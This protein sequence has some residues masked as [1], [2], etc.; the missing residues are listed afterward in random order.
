[1][2]CDVHG[3]CFSL[4]GIVEKRHLSLTWH[5]EI[6]YS[7]EKDRKKQF[8]FL[9]YQIYFEFHWK[10]LCRYLAIR[11]T[12]RLRIR[13]IRSEN[14][15]ME[16]WMITT[17]EKR[18]W[19]IFLSTRYNLFGKLMIHFSFSPQVHT[20]NNWENAD[21]GDDERKQKFLRLMGAK[22]V[23]RWDG[24]LR[25]KNSI[26]LF[27]NTKIYMRILVLQWIGSIAVQVRSS[28]VHVSFTR[29][30]VDDWFAFF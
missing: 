9:L 5:A 4:V 14:T 12:R 13:S 15:T 24:L 26:I 18:T 23:K 17:E 11:K 27:R 28:A 20:V 6:E 7:L 21:L 2:S 25:R 16:E 10:E 30:D 1:M 19:I 29:R 8:L 22:V 3:R